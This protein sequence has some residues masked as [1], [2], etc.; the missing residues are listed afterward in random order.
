[1]SQDKNEESAPVLLS[2]VEN[3]LHKARDIFLPDMGKRDAGAWVEFSDA[4]ALVT[5]VRASLQHG[6]FVQAFES[7]QGLYRTVWALFERYGDHSDGVKTSL[8]Y[9][10][11]AAAKLQDLMAAAVR[12]AQKR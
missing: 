7:A 1:M 8:R 2:K 4:L 11:D 5:S 3:E 6:R 9:A 12:L 10:Q